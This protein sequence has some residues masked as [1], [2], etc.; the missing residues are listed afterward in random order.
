MATIASSC[1]HLLHLIN[2]ILDLSK[3]DAG[4]M[5]LAPVDFDLVALVRE[6]AAMFQHPCEEKKLGLRVEASTG[7]APC[8][9]AATKGSCGRCS[10]IC[11]ATP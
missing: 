1:D 4:R 9:C 2:E 3:I 6:L 7:R 10:S 5:E 11:S 8:R